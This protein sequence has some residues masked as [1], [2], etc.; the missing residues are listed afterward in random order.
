[1]LIIAKQVFMKNVRSASWIFLVLSPVLLLGISIGIGHL[2]QSSQ[3]KPTIGVVS[4][5]PAIRKTFADS[6]P[7]MKVK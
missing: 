5:V 4:T 2:V 3:S 1:M 7:G 6:L